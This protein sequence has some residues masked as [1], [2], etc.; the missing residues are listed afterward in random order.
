MGLESWQPKYPFCSSTVGTKHSLPSQILD[1]QIACLWQRCCT[2]R[3]VNILELRIPNITHVEVPSGRDYLSPVKVLLSI[4][5]CRT[6]FHREK[7]FLVHLLFYR[8]R[9]SSRSGR[10]YLSMTCGSKEYTL[11]LLILFLLRDKE[12]KKIHGLYCT[13]YSRL[14][15][16]ERKPHSY[17]CK[18]T[19]QSTKKWV[20]LNQRTWS[21]TPTSYPK[22]MTYV[23]L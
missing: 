3:S 18:T 7:Q 10:M 17:L 1:L 11:Y 22:V 8:W 4:Y 6:A 2:R 15:W 5:F 21:R 14:D 12:E 9:A 23:C 20:A 16:G 19:N 13:T